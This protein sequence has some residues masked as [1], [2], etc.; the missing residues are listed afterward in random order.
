M[1]RY[2]EQE[3]RGEVRGEVPVDA[4]LEELLNEL[5]PHEVGLFFWNER[6]KHLKQT[7]CA[8]LMGCHMDRPKMEQDQVMMIPPISIRTIQI[9][10]IASICRSFPG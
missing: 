4:N 2:W 6:G 8:F 1:K 3:G 7:S 5:P 9:R 10:Q